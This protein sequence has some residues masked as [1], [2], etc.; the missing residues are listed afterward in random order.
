MMKPIRIMLIVGGLLC[1]MV[2]FPS[3]A[4]AYTTTIDGPGNCE[5]AATNVWVSGGNGAFTAE[6]NSGY[7]NCWR[8]YVTNF[9]GSWGIGGS[10]EDYKGYSNGTCT[11]HRARHNGIN[12]STKV[13]CPGW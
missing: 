13:A 10:V 12:S 9:W 4:E 2:A 1:A 7:H 8:V 11:S 3:P 5:A 6:T